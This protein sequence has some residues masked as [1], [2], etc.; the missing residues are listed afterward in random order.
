M[1]GTTSCEDRAS[2]QTTNDRVISRR[3]MEPQSADTQTA[4][5]KDRHLSGQVKVSTGR[6]EGGGET[7]A[8]VGHTKRQ[9][10]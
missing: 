10:A 8:N 9:P 4:V 5:T 6:G 7:E 2:N 1:A 3:I